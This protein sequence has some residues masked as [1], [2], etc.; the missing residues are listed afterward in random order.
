VSAPA[1]DESRRLPAGAHGIPAAVVA[2]NQRERLVAAA[3]EACAER[4]YAETS[5]AD[6]AHRAGVS[7][8]TF[9][10]LFSDKREC[11]L[12]A[13]R[14]LLARLL[15]EVDA[16]CAATPEEE[17]KVR[18]GARTLLALLAADAPAARLLTVEVLAVGAAGAVR[19]DAAIESF[20]SRL[21]AGGGRDGSSGSQAEW[22]LVAGIAAL[23]GNRVMAG[24]A[25]N[26]PQLEDELVAMAAA[27]G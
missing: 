14:E 15:E 12:E 9:Y 6:V 17:G 2:R 10:N 13:H 8:A 11:V 5:V 27:L 4:G 24:E 19:N 23:I 3:A 26:L 21:R 16:A 20:A 18:A 22:V 7:T 25:A 1:G